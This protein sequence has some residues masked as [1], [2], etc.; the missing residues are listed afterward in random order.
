MLRLTPTRIAGPL[1]AGLIFAAAPLGA[2][3]RPP[4][5]YI[6]NSH[7]DAVQ[8]LAPPPAPGSLAQQ[9]D[10]AAVRAG[11]ALAGRPRWARAQ[12]DDDLSPFTAFG[13]VLGRRFTA[14]RAPKTAALFTVLFNDVKTQTAPAKDHFGRLRPPLVDRSIKTCRPLEQTK[15]YPSGHASRG[16]MMALVLSDVLPEKADALLARGRDYGDS[17]VVCGEH[18][19]SDVEA[20]RLIGA[21]VFAAAMADPIFR[22]DLQAVRAELRPLLLP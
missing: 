1:A 9:A 18:F 7:L 10:G 2:I 12:S 11:Q 3:A 14:G 19:P 17:R 15:S 21:S 8:F 20:G 16:W 13:P 5:S 22:R 6:A 4:E